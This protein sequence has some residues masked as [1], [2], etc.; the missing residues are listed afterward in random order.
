MTRTLAQDE[1]A[2]RNPLE[3]VL[4]VKITTYSDHDEETVEATYYLSD[5]PVLYDY[6]NTGTDRGFLAFVQGVSDVTYAIQHVPGDDGG[7]F[8]KELTLTLANADYQGTRFSEVLRGKNILLGH[9]EVA[10]VLRDPGSALAWWDLTDLTGTEHIVWFRGDCQ[11]LASVDDDQLTLSIQAEHT[12]VSEPTATAAATVDPKDL[13][14][15]Y[16]QPIGE[17]KRVQAIG[18]VVGWA[19]TLSESIS[20]TT[21]GTT[22]MTDV[23]GLPAATTFELLLA[24]E[25]VTCSGSDPVGNSVTITARG[26]NGTSAGGHDAGEVCV[27]LLATS[28]FVVAPYPVASVDRVYLHNPFND[29]LFAVE[30]DYSTNLFDTS[31]V[32]GLTVSS[33]SFTQAQMLDALMEAQTVATVSTQAE[34]DDDTPEAYSYAVVTGDTRTLTSPPESDD[35]NWSDTSGA[36]PIWE[37]DEASGATTDS[38][39][40]KFVGD[41]HGSGATAVHRARLRYTANAWDWDPGMV[42]IRCDFDGADFP[43]A[44]DATMNVSL[45]HTWTSE[46][47]ATVYGTWSDALDDT[48][49]NLFTDSII[50]LRM[51]GAGGFYDMGKLEMTGGTWGIEIEYGAASAVSRTVDAEI[52]AAQ[53]G[54]GASIYV[55]VSGYVA[56]Y[57]WATLHEFAG[58][59]SYATSNCTA[60]EETTIVKSGGESLKVVCDAFVDI[61]AM[62]DSESNWTASAG[63]VKQ[64]YLADTQVSDCESTTGWTAYECTLVASTEQ[65]HEGTKSIRCH[66][67]THAAAGARFT[68]A[69][70][71]DMRGKKVSAWVYNLT[72][73]G[74]VRMQCRSST[75]PVYDLWHSKLATTYA[76]YGT[77]TLVEFDMESAATRGGLHASFD[78]TSVVDFLWYFSPGV[79]GGSVQYWDDFRYE[80]HHNEGSGAI[81]HS[82][83]TSFPYL[84]RGDLTSMDLTNA[85]ITVDVW[86]GDDSWWITTNGIRCLVSHLTSGAPPADYD[87]VDVTFNS[88][89]AI[90]EGAWNSLVFDFSGSLQGGSGATMTSIVYLGLQQRSNG[91]VVEYDDI[92]ATRGSVV[93]QYNAADQGDW[94]SYENRYKVSVRADN[95]SDVS[96]IRVQFSDEV[97]TGTTA[98]SAYEELAI[99][100]AALSEDTWVTSSH[101]SDTTGSPTLDAVRTVRVEIDMIAAPSAN[102]TV[103][104]DKLEYVDEGSS[105]AYSVAGGV[106]I[107]N[108]IDVFRMLL[109][110][111]GR[112]DASSLDSSS[113]G[114]HALTYASWKIAGDLRLI[115]YGFREKISRLEE[116][117]GINLIRAE[118][119]SGVEWRVSAPSNALD[120]YGSSSKTLGSFFEVRELGTDASEVAA[121]FAFWYAPNLVAETFDVEGFTALVR[122][123]VEQNDISGTV[124]TSLLIAAEAAFGAVHADAVP[125]TM[126]QDQTTAEAR[127]AYGVTHGIDILPTYEGE[128]PWWDA[129]DLELGDVVSVPIPWRASVVKVRVVGITKRWSDGIM[130]LRV[131]EVT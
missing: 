122:A 94:D 45:P 89:G 60:S 47:N 85:T 86:I 25:Q 57:N 4:L 78:I 22:K 79:S 92:R 73:G 80:S 77:W 82:A 27:E 1:L 98:P 87:Y 110:Y 42:E 26:A 10:S 84:W 34:Y 61:H 106:L 72:S 109:T 70:P 23:S 64:T 121:R 97:E 125:L 13:G 111:L 24:G 128:A 58:G 48:F 99:S 8:N 15:R 7:Q 68:P 108:P 69:S 129:L 40:V 112:E 51:V 130:A 30:N 21:T 127:A 3:P 33:V 55:D 81:W 123:D 32:P 83:S 35:G 38:L 20:S 114:L 49:S 75:S 43:A 118:A 12:R 62:D 91:E 90:V 126:I 11:S 36:A 119:N 74:Y 19:T 52:V 95:A 14:R 54:F 88:M 93:A 53:F 59:G 124:A 18:E 37:N 102:P 31:T 56:D 39:E 116:E 44:A 113:F 65:V 46:G 71:L 5:R 16:P 9:V 41:E 104:I 103:Y 117:T 67:D 105:S 50:T 115:G 101:V 2:R 120:T 100:G 107:E 66:T 96:E 76:P 131:V 63:T 29:E 6:G 28:T 17:A